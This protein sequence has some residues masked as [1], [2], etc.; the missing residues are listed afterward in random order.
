[1]LASMVGGVLVP[2]LPA[3]DHQKRHET[4]LA[5]RTRTCP[6]LFSVKRPNLRLTLRPERDTFNQDLQPSGTLRRY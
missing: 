1:M 2:I 5:M 4:P 6:R 3:G